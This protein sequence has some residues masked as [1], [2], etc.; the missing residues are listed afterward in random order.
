MKG[1]NYEVNPFL[2]F[3]HIF[4][5]VGALF[6]AT[7]RACTRALAKSLETPEQRVIRVEERHKTGISY[8]QI[9]KEEG[10]SPMTFY[11]CVFLVHV[12]PRAPHVGARMVPPPRDIYLPAPLYCMIAL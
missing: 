12:H 6:M 1:Q 5:C 3:P 9:L 11:K 7:H 8:E 4:G 2:N 10:I